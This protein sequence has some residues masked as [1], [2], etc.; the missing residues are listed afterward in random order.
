MNNSAA[1]YRLRK[2][3]MHCTRCARARMPE[4]NGNESV[5]RIPMMT[6]TMRISS[7]ENAFVA[8]RQYD[9][10]KL[11]REGTATLA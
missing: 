7:S 10:N 2:F 1:A 11:R 8:L 4:T 3:A 9:R 6:K 5:T